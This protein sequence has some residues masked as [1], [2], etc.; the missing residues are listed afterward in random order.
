ME[1]LFT[2]RRLRDRLSTRTHLV[3]K[4]GDVVAKRVTQRL[5]ELRSA[6][7]LADMRNLPG[8]CHELTGDRTGELAVNL[9]AQHRLIFRPAENPAP[10]KPDG[11]LDWDAVTDVVVTE[12]VDYH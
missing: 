12:I 7:T 6:E 8:K 10:Q 4:Y 3:K 1:V 9:D 2:D 5:Q 11:G